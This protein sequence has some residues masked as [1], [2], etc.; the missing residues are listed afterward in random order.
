MPVPA[1]EM[2]FFPLVFF[3]FHSLFDTADSSSYPDSYKA[4][5][6][7]FFVSFY[8]LAGLVLLNVVVAVLLDEVCNSLPLPLAIQCRA[9]DRSRFSLSVY[10]FAC[11]PIP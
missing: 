5:I 6:S 8:L 2:F 10:A 7:L 9:D 3:V 11:F 4:S 1:S